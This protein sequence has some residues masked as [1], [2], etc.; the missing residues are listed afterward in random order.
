MIDPFYWRTLIMS[1]EY[2]S[3]ESLKK[4]IVLSDGSATLMRGKSPTCRKVVLN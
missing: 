2:I 1:G 4:R 3:Q